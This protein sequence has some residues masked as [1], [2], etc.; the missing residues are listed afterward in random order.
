MLRSLRPRRARKTE[1]IILLATQCRNE[2]ARGCTFPLS[3]LLTRIN[4]RVSVAFP[5]R[6]VIYF[7]ARTPRC[8]RRRGCS[9]RCGD[10]AWGSPGRIYFFCRVP[11]RYRTHTYMYIYNT[12]KRTGG[13][14]RRAELDSTFTFAEPD[15]VPAIQLK[16]A[17][18]PL[19]VYI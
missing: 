16:P 5:S 6:M 19:C 15:S 8:G 4:S 7:T 12:R 2:E 1:Q 14:P 3:L 11:A 10:I 13:R 9:L 18:V 17:R